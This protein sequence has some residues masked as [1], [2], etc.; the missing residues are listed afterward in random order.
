MLDP[1]QR[2]ETSSRLA[3][4]FRRCRRLQR[5][6]SQLYAEAARLHSLCAAI[7]GLSLC[8]APKD[9]W[10][11]PRPL[12]L[13]IASS[14]SASKST[15]D[16]LLR[17]PVEERL[18][19]AME[20]PADCTRRV[21]HLH[22]SATPRLA[23]KRAD[24]AEVASC[25]NFKTL[26][27]ADA[28]AHEMISTPAPR[29][30]KVSYGLPHPLL[31]SGLEVIDLP[32]FNVRSAEFV[33]DDIEQVRSCNP[34]VCLYFFHLDSAMDVQRR[35]LKAL[36]SALVPQGCR[37]VL[38]A[39][40]DD[41]SV[42]GDE[43]HLKQIRRRFPEVKFMVSPQTVLEHQLDGAHSPSHVGPRLRAWVRL[44]EAV[45]EALERSCNADVA[46][47]AGA[48]RD[49]LEAMRRLLTEF[50]TERGDRAKKAR[51]AEAV[52]AALGGKLMDH[53]TR[54]LRHPLL[55]LKA[56]RYA[57]SCES[58]VLPREKVFSR[59]FALRLT[60]V[61]LTE[62]LALCS[63]AVQRFSHHF[64]RRILERSEFLLEKHF[65]RAS[66]RL[67]ALLPP[68]ATAEL[69]RS[70]AEYRDMALPSDA[71]RAEI[72]D[73]VVGA[74]V[75]FLSTAPPDERCPDALRAEVQK[76]AAQ[77]LPERLSN[78]A[79][80]GIA[81]FAESVRQPWR[82]RAL[83]EAEL[84]Q[85]GRVERRLL[86]ALHLLQAR[87]AALCWELG[88]A[89]VVRHNGVPS[90]ATPRRRAT[91]AGHLLTLRD[92]APL[93]PADSPVVPLR[94]WEW[95]PLRGFVVFKPQMGAGVFDQLRC[96]DAQRRTQFASNLAAAAA[97]LLDLQCSLRG[98][99]PVHLVQDTTGQRLMLDL[100]AL[101][102]ARAQE[103]FSRL[104]VA[105]YCL[106][107]LQLR[108]E[109]FENSAQEHTP[110]CDLYAITTYVWFLLLG[111]AF[112]ERIPQAV[113]E[114]AGPSGLAAALRTWQVTAPPGTS[115]PLQMKLEACRELEIEA[116][117]KA[118][119]YCRMLAEELQQ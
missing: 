69:P 32:G 2:D 64:Q 65:L 35:L 62:A 67:R 50:V 45:A 94:Q 88:E 108:P 77:V 4:T 22:A 113:M 3:S 59:L 60:D 74:A 41:D 101:G 102:A 71:F 92:L 37:F 84:R 79:A 57:M 112:V 90:R 47:G 96:L 70:L 39:I 54:E 86:P 73:V 80:E 12:R 30:L 8:G 20:T 83:S 97:A 82:E 1:C 44:E 76:E 100:E 118:Q 16:L 87:L 55:K 9:L 117:T 116:K 23:L 19:S 93:L 48:L 15:A 17:T 63:V 75:R 104:N 21:V 106:P 10:R 49:R 114:A 11:A 66:R 29:S 34:I 111:D 115:R 28:R 119:Q 26:A 25:T 40:Q 105:G 81:Q 58:P 5:D 18:R 85:V 51:E 98:L 24:N 52:V 33:K 14:S 36:R 78:V 61:L 27:E 68:F 95:R 53:V 99:R 13:L 107:P 31:E 6:L 89:P 38:A 46:R 109:R 103:E 72:A 43:E 42:S 7:G 56:E 91:A 110:S